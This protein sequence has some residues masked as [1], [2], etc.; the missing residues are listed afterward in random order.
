MPLL[1]QG[2]SWLNDFNHVVQNPV[3]KPISKVLFTVVVHLLGWI[4]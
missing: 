4:I 1:K 2:G 3:L